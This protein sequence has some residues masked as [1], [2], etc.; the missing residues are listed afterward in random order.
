M[1]YKEISKA[2]YLREVSDAMRRR[3]YTE[4][5]RLSSELQAQASIALLHG[6]GDQ[7]PWLYAD[8]TNYLALYWTVTGEKVQSKGLIATLNRMELLEKDCRHKA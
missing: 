6:V 8:T 7:F 5:E 2:A 3:S 1:L 4:V